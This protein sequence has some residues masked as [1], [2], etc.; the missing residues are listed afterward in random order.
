MGSVTKKHRIGCERA[1]QNDLLE[2]GEIL[3]APC[4]CIGISDMAIWMS[5]QKRF[6][7]RKKLLPTDFCR[8]LC[9]K[10]MS[11]LIVGARRVSGRLMMQ[12]E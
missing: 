1:V 6:T 2:Q 4:R 10:L 3:I 8:S 12:A 5:R 11:V 9:L 7:Y